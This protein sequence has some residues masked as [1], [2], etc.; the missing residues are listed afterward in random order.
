VHGD[1]RQGAQAGRRREQG[2]RCLAAAP[3]A[4]AGAQHRIGSAPRV[5]PSLAACVRLPAVLR[6]RLA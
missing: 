1:G 2:R 6:C 4:G 3:R 5:S